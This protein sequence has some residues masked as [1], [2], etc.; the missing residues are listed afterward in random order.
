MAET[1]WIGH[2]RL[3]KRKM[4]AEGF[5]WRGG[6]SRVLGIAPEEAD[7]VEMPWCAKCAKGEPNAN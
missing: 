1:V 7:K 5:Q 2:A 6:D 3:H 4:C